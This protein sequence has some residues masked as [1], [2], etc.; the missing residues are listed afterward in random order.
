M[1]QEKNKFTLNDV[2]DHLL[3]KMIGRHP[4]VF[5]DVNADTP[6]KALAS[7]ESMKISEVNSKT[8]RKRKLLEGVPIDLPASASSLFDFH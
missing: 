3:A 1:M 7:W 6:E 5:G 8:G 2:L 4:H